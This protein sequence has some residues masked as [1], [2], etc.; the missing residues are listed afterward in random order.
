MIDFVFPKTPRITRSKTASAK[1]GLGSAIKT[2]AAA[3][4]AG[5]GKKLYSGWSGKRK[6]EIPLR[7]ASRQGRVYADPG[8]PFSKKGKYGLSTGY[9]RGKIKTRRK[10][11]KLEYTKEKYMAT[12]ACTSSEF[13]GNVANAQC[14]YIGHSTYTFNQTRSCIAKAMCRTLLKLAGLDIDN[15]ERV[16]SLSYDS[17]ASEH[18]IVLYG[19]PSTGQGPP[20]EVMRYDFPSGSTLKSITESFTIGD[21][22]INLIG[23]AMQNTFNTGASFNFDR[24]DL[25]LR[26]K[27]SVDTLKLQAS[28]NLRQYRCEVFS[29]SIL[30]I[31]NRSKGATS[32]D[33]DSTAVDNQPLRG[34]LYEFSKGSVSTKQQGTIWNQDPVSM[35]GT[36]LKN[37]ASF[38]TAALGNPWKEPQPAKV[39]NSCNKSRHVRLQPGDIKS[40]SIQHVYKGSDFNDL[41]YKL[42]TRSANTDPS[43]RG[44]Q[45]AAGKAQMFAL[46]ELI[47]TGSLNEIVVQFEIDKVIGCMFKKVKKN[48]M[49]IHHEEFPIVP[50]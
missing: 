20:T 7:K 44:I 37:A 33:V 47:N 31:Q 36:I 48:L 35:N 18:S 25:Y 1:R 9:Y 12:G 32:G 38:T 4:A 50:A 8:N 15:D 3:A 27:A 42:T 16:I 5:A 26:D 45:Q 40:A 30:K 19:T 43:N 24:I 34:L 23:A 21:A 14:V 46:E 41:I 11:S 49:L 17:I 28:M 6:L 39:F 22:L 13:Y 2:I 29:K 10:R